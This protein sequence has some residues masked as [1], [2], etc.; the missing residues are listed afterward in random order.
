MLHRKH[1]FVVEYDDESEQFSISYNQQEAKF[2]G[3]PIYNVSTDEW[4]ELGPH[5]RDF[6]SPQNRA[7]YALEEVVKSSLKVF[8]IGWR[9]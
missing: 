4:E 7:A 9:N 8:P 1:Y 6:D 2:G 3:A 5:L